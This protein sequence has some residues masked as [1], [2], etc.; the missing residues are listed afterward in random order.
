MILKKNITKAVR[1]EFD[2]KENEVV[3]AA[4]KV[5][6]EVRP[7]PP[8]RQKFNKKRMNALVSFFLC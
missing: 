6:P 5:Q 3:A 7:P 2:P 8:F 4:E 1:K